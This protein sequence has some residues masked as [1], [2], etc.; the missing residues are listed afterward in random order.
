MFELE[1]EY[2]K[3]KYLYYNGKTEISDADFDKLEEKIRNLGSELPNIVG[4]PNLEI[5][6]KYELLTILVTGNKDLHFFHPYP[7]LSLRKHHMTEDE[8]DNEIK[9]DDLNLFFNKKPNATILCEPKFDGNSM[10]LIYSYG[11][12]IQGLT[13]G[14]DSDGGGIDKIEKMKFIV[15][16]VIGNG[17]EKYKKVVI[18]GENIIHLITWSV[19]YSDPNKVDNPRNWLAG[20]FNND[21]VNV[22]ILSDIDFIAY[23]ITIVEDGELIRPINQLDELKTLG[24]KEFFHMYAKDYNDFF[25]NVF[26]A[27]KQHRI[28]SDYAL[29]GIVLSYPTDCWDEMGESSHHP[30]HSCALKFV[31]NKVETILINIVWKVSKDGELAPR[32]VLKPV[33]LDGSVVSYA[34]LYNLGWII[35]NKVFPGCL[36]ELVKHGDIIPGINKILKESLENDEYQKYLEKTIINLSI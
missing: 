16:Q 28:D 14:S 21:E 34:S 19:K 30:H 35:E 18:R 4:S 25:E 20:V 1:R 6:K 22:D 7:M 27:F 32:A 24:F 10:E 13:R 11:K 17:Y 12:L 8:H 2:L 33:E 26:P 23:Q 9:P 31:P 29:D 5:L 36:V 15:P 3:H